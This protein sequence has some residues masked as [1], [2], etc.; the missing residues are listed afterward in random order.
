M[1]TKEELIKLSK[2]TTRCTHELH[3]CFEGELCPQSHSTAC[4]LH[5]TSATHKETDEET[6]KIIKEKGHCGDS[7]AMCPRGQL[8]HF[9][10][11]L[12]TEKEATA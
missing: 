3:E 9:Y 4:C 1:K 12:S 7:T 2:K 11:I 8:L 10:G 5:C 6:M